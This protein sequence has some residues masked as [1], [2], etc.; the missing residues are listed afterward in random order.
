MPWNEV[1]KMDLKEEFVLHALKEGSNISELCRRY[2]I[3]RK[4]GYKLLARYKEQGKGGLEERSRQPKGQPFKTP[5]EMEALI[6]EERKSHPCWGANKLKRVLEDKGIE[7]VPAKSSV[8]RI[9]DRHG[10]LRPQ[11]VMRTEKW[12]FFEHE[13]SNDLWQ[14]DFKGHFEIGEGRCHPLTIIDDHSRFSIA[15]NAYD[16]EQGRVVKEGLIGAFRRYG[17]PLRINVDNGAPWGSAGQGN[18]TTLSIWLMRVGV[19]VSFSRMFHPQTNGKDE[20]FHRTLKLE[21]LQGRYFKTLNETQIVFDEWRHIYNTKRPHESLQMDVPMSRYTPSKRIYPEILP[22]I[23][24]D[25]SD[26]IRK[27]RHKGYISFRHRDHY[28]GKGF[29]GEHVAVRPTLEDGVF[30]VFYGSQKIKSIDLTISDK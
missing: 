27:V 1:T 7:N 13:H 12:D 18:Y 25:K 14:M 5:Y 2:G 24:Y 9:L 29:I 8:N 3:S 26:N 22:E 15:L 28:V 30:E 19:K 17:M 21:V 16:N 6:L 11:E 20:R 23:E 4:T 10:L